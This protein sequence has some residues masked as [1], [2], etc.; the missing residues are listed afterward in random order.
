MSKGQK[1]FLGIV[2]RGMQ[3]KTLTV[4]FVRLEDGIEAYAIDD[5]IWLN[6]SREEQLHLLQSA[7]DVSPSNEGEL[8]LVG[9]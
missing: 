8:I 4:Y 1:V 3:Q 7:K 5:R 2:T 9:N 6:Y